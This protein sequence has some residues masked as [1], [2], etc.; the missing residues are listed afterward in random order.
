MGN[1]TED[2]KIEQGDG[3]KGDLQEI[4]QISVTSNSVLYSNIMGFKR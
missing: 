3:F 4:S 2:A 1:K